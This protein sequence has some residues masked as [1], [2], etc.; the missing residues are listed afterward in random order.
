MKFC[1][2]VFIFVCA[3]SSAQ[4]AKMQTKTADSI[5][6]CV[7]A[8]IDTLQ[9]EPA[10]FVGSVDEYEFQGRRVYAFGPSKNL[11]DGSTYVMTADCKTLCNIGG[12]AGPKN[13]GCNGENFFEKAVLKRRLWPLR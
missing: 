5:P 9:K 7:Q 12:F 4:Q 8:Y 6:K 10:G 3:C 13:S 2:I 11:M 1:F